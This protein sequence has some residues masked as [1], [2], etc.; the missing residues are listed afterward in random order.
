MGLIF[1][2]SSI[3][4]DMWRKAK[5]KFEDDTK[6]KVKKPAEKVLGV[7]RKSSGIES[8]FNNL[9]QISL[10]VWDA[11]T[12]KDYDKQK[13]EFLKAAAKLNQV[14]EAYVK[15]LEAAAEKEFAAY[16]PQ[17]IELRDSLKK[18]VKTFTDRMNNR[19][20]FK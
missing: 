6:K 16:K 3:A 1:G 20:G 4:I 13:G 9:D 5:K 18:Q 12:Q 7:W 14:T 8:A 2:K 10:K 11:K 17:V 15:L 19:N